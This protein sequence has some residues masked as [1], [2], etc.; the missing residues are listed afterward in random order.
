MTHRRV[1]CVLL[2]L[3]F[4]VVLL[5]CSR[6]EPAAV[7][8]EKAVQPPTGAT[9]K[10]DLGRGPRTVFAPAP[11]S[12]GATKQDASGQEAVT[13]APEAISESPNTPG[14]TTLEERILMADAIAVVQLEHVIGVYR[15][16]TS[17]LRAS[18]YKAFLEVT[19]RV[20]ET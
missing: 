15:Q 9:T 16:V 17:G 18:K 6:D 20:E 14:D 5:S 19:Y 3:A 7:A 10:A 4:V 1:I 2:L 11:Y 12:G 13:D 8:P